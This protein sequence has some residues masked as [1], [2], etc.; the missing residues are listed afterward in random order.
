MMLVLFHAEDL[1]NQIQ[2]AH[3]AH[4]RIKR[5]LAGRQ[6]GD[7]KAQ[8]ELESEPGP[9]K[10]LSRAFKALIRD[11]VITEVERKGIEPALAFRNDIAHDLHIL[12]ADLSNERWARDLVQVREFQKTEDQRPLSGLSKLKPLHLPQHDYDALDKIRAFS[13]LLSQRVREQQRAS[14]IRM[15]SMAFSAAERVYDAELKRLDR[16]IDRLL[17]ERDAEDEALRREVDLRGTGLEDFDSPGHPYSSYDDG[18]LTKRGVEIC[19]RLF[20]LGKSPLAVANLFRIS[21]VSARKRL[22]MW[23]ALGGKERPAVDLD[24]LPRRVFYLDYDD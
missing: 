6:G 3:E 9:N 5:A 19:Y 1:R 17:N 2:D 4:E 13:K 7:P 14:S 10:R 18:R 12:T 11:G 24:A 20:D 8:A 15:V 22:G 21:L 16:I 23:K